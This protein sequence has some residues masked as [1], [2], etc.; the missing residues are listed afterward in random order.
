[1][2]N[3]L[4]K[5]PLLAAKF[6]S[7]SETGKIKLGLE[8]NGLGPAIIKKITFKSKYIESKKCQDVF[9]TIKLK[10]GSNL[11]FNLKD[12]VF[13]EFAD[14]YCVHEKK[15]ILIYKATIT[16]PSILTKNLVIDHILKCKMLITYSDIFGN[17]VEQIEKIGV[18]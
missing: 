1:M 8:N 15:Y 3:V 2:N 13:G 12:T 16:D 18:E 5:K 14:K 7:N 4:S 11:D 6:F 9:H 10:N 17:E